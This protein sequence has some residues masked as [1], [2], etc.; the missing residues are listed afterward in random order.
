[1]NSVQAGFDNGTDHRNVFMEMR[2]PVGRN[3][4]M[5]DVVLSSKNHLT[6]NLFFN[7][8]RRPTSEN[9]FTF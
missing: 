2:E 3:P 1:M 7:G 4:T 8:M 9:L 6:S 5:L